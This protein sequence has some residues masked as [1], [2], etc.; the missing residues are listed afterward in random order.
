MQ[1]KKNF[2]L[3]LAKKPVANITKTQ[4]MLCDLGP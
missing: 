1:V 4:I 2:Y 3:I